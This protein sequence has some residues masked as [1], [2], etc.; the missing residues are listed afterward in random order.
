MA[1]FKIGKKIGNL[2]DNAGW[3]YKSYTDYIDKHIGLCKVWTE[4]KEDI[5]LYIFFSI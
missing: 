3:Y 2:F 5:K 1:T 4:Q